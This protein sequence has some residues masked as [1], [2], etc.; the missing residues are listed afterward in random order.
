MTIKADYAWHSLKG[1]RKDKTQNNLKG[2]NMLLWV[3]N[4]PVLGL[5]EFARYNKATREIIRKAYESSQQIIEGMW[6]TKC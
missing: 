5:L 4:M 1:I 6:R 2:E 3:K